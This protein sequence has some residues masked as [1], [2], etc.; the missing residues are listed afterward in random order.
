MMWRNIMLTS[1]CSFSAMTE[2]SH[3]GLYV[4]DSGCSQDYLMDRHFWSIGL[5]WNICKTYQ[6][7][8]H[9]MFRGNYLNHTNWQM[10]HLDSGVCIWNFIVQ[11]LCQSHACSFCTTWFI[12]QIRIKRSL[13]SLH[14]SL[15]RVHRMQK[16][17]TWW[18]QIPPQVSRA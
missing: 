7:F 2:T 11:L 1:F 14:E 3:Q 12:S 8:L 9:F 15:L 16:Y 4:H 10:N 6:H 17:R 13:M 18:K 5:Y